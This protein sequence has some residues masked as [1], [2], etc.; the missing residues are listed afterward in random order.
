MY[1]INLTKIS[2]FLSLL[3][4]IGCGN[5]ELKESE[6]LLGIAIAD[7]NHS[8]I[9]IHADSVLSIDPENEDLITYGKWIEKQVSDARPTLPTELQKELSLNPF[10]RCED[11]V[12]QKLY[13]SEDPVEVFRKMR[14]AKDNF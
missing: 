2:I 8:E 6:R 14:L 1:Q 12:F 5:P 13:N 10:L 9:L 4:L 7:K 3:L 11:K